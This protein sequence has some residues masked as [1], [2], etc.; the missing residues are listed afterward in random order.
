MFH[1]VNFNCFRHPK[2]VN[3]ACHPDFSLPDLQRNVLCQNEF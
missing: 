1:N 2:P 3:S